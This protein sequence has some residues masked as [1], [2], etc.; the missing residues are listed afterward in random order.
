VD[1]LEAS[2]A[3]GMQ[4]MTTQDDRP[5]EDIV[6]QVVLMFVAV[7]A[8]LILAL[9]VSLAF[10]LVHG[11]YHIEVTQGTDVEIHTESALF[12]AEQLTEHLRRELPHAHVTCL[13]CTMLGTFLHLPM[14]LARYQIGE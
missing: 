1:N 2:D 10:L 9:S 11:P 4:T 7:G 3:R 14:R 5:T 13:D 8:G 6:T 12:F